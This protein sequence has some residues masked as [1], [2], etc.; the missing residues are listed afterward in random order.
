MCFPEAI[1][2]LRVPLP[3]CVSRAHMSYL[4]TRCAVANGWKNFAKPR[5]RKVNMCLG[6]LVFIALILEKGM[7][8]LGGGFIF[9][10]FHP[11]L[12]K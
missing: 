9:F 5:D 1:R 10:Y 6:R 2:T 12:G 8:K 4:S 11:Y 7:G 3:C